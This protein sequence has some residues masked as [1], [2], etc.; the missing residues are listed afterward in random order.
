VVFLWVDRKSE[1]LPVEPLERHFDDC[2]ECREH[3]V[4]VERVVLLLRSRC[5]REAPPAGLAARI[6]GLFDG[7]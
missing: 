5:R 4:R 6:R 7:N 1:T 2:P 3:A